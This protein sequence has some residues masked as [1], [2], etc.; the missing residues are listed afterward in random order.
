[1]DYP[2]ARARSSRT[3]RRWSRPPAFAASRA[4]P[5]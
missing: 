5:T 3:S 1:M 4:L 2:I